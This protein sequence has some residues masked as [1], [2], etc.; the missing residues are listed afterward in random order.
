MSIPNFKYSSKRD[1]NGEQKGVEFTAKDIAKCYG[2]RTFGGLART[3]SRWNYQLK[4][5]EKLTKEEVLLGLER[6]V[7]KK[8]LEELKKNSEAE[9]KE[10]E[11]T[12]KPEGSFKVTRIF[13]Q[14]IKN[15]G[16]QAISNRIEGIKVQAEAERHLSPKPAQPPGQVIQQKPSKDR[17]DI[18]EESQLE[19]AEESQIDPLLLKLREQ[20]IPEEFATD[21]NSYLLEEGVPEEAIPKLLELIPKKDRE[22]LLPVVVDLNQK[23]GIQFMLQNIPSDRIGIYLKLHREG[24]KRK[25][26][27]SMVI[28]GT[29]ENMSEKDINDAISLIKMGKEKLFREI[30]REYPEEMREGKRKLEAIVRLEE[31]ANIFDRKFIL[32]NA[33]EDNINEYIDE[34]IK[35]FTISAVNSYKV[36]NILSSL[37]TQSDNF[38]LKNVGFS[39]LIK[40]Y[41]KGVSLEV[42]E[43]IVFSGIR[44]NIFLENESFKIISKL[45]ESGI[46][47]DDLLVK[48]SLVL[49]S[50]NPT[51]NEVEKFV[52]DAVYLN[53][54][55]KMPKD[56]ISTVLLELPQDSEER[57]RY[58]SDFIYFYENGVL[59]KEIPFL[60]K[61]LNREELLESLEDVKKLNE[62]KIKR[63]ANM[64]GALV[65]W[66]DR[67]LT[68]Q[69]KLQILKI[70]KEKRDI[71][72]ICHLYK[73]EVPTD[74]IVRIFNI[75]PEE[76]RKAYIESFPSYNLVEKVA[77]NLDPLVLLYFLPSYIKTEE[78][79]EEMAKTCDTGL[80]AGLG[81]FEVISGAVRGLPENSPQWQERSYKIFREEILSLS[82]A[83]REFE[84]ANL[85]END[86]I[87]INKA[88]T[89]I[90]LHQR[91]NALEFVV[92]LF[93]SNL[94]IE[95][96][97]QACKA[98]DFSLFNSPQQK[99]DL[100]E[101]IKIL[102]ERKILFDDVIKMITCLSE[103]D[104]NT[105]VKE[106]LYR[107]M[108]QISGNASPVML[109]ALLPDELKSS[110]ALEKIKNEGGGG[111]EYRDA[112]KKS[113]EHHLNHLGDINEAFAIE[114]VKFVNLIQRDL[115]LT[116]NDPLL[117]L[118]GSLTWLE[119]YRESGDP[120]GPYAVF[121]K[122][123]EELRTPSDF[124]FKP[125]QVGNESVAINI[126]Q[127]KTCSLV[128]VVKRE[129][130][131]K[132]ATFEAWMQ[133]CNSFK[134][135]VMS[136]PNEA[137]KAMTVI[138]PSQ[139]SDVGLT[140]KSIDET[141]FKDK[142]LTRLV[143]SNVGYV[144][145][146]EAKWRA[147]LSNLLKK[148]DVPR[149]GEFF[150]EREEIFCRYMTAI[151]NCTGGKLQGIF[152]LYNDL[153]VKD[154]YEGLSTRNVSADEAEE[155]EK[156]AK[157]L[158]KVMDLIKGKGSREEKLQA[159]ITYSKDNLKVSIEEFNALSDVDDWEWEDEFFMNQLELN[160]AGAEKLVDLAENAFL[161]PV[162]QAV[163]GLM[164]RQFS[165]GSDLLHEL[166]STPKD[167]NINQ[168]PHQL[169]YLKN[170]IEP[171]LSGRKELEFDQYTGTIENGFIKLSREQVLEAF[172]RHM[173]PQAMIKE[174]QRVINNNQEFNVQF[175]GYLPPNENYWKEQKLTDEG[176]LYLLKEAN[177]ITG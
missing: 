66:D 162:R 31:T 172:E 62:V 171:I 46:K 48:V 84:K 50:K 109:Y 156:A 106:D 54:Y 83:A 170:L 99:S 111:P 151:K 137:Q 147:V 132:D 51:S 6:A 136:N 27:L 34:V 134:T 42:I 40:T 114:I 89:R 119:Q 80:N 38:G 143:E 174:V 138:S 5:G 148:S 75:I 17:E 67:K 3:F 79:F 11:I 8:P 63:Y 110:Q 150:S 161:S 131:P 102:Y 64:G 153:E 130:L 103:K 94:P 24:I 43:N 29:K 160:Q 165:P 20:G 28:K 149:E 53:E 86:L 166:T 16:T 173:T 118:A 68:V 58:V 122:L 52:K 19:T 60:L 25:N 146:G 47:D 49:L 135:K 77:G 163:S 129:D 30:I 56:F 81:Y 113:C 108:K 69:E 152:A 120:K 74:Q 124:K 14:G 55:P 177:F 37:K 82:N 115:G 125:V 158:N 169:I 76:D 112:I 78:E 121:K 142:L 9:P 2:K 107:V 105:M 88:F 167:E 100:I 59:G 22:T 92:P 45:Y 128:S 39:E 117:Q 61:K 32:D 133:L 176:A 13:F 87:E 155:V 33:P 18:R 10:F 96:I 168:S 12:E 71:D 126:N 65:Y 90:P 1:I 139:G 93:R 164:E 73:K 159:L 36:N 145:E 127:L 123:K 116:E 91:K 26:F 95:N 35:I 175:R 44:S 101:T 23:E 85:S 57:N 140:W 154:R 15:L 7:A 41:N 98:I 70:P 4:H 157:S 144:S 97:V 21:Y 141:V 72:A 104:R